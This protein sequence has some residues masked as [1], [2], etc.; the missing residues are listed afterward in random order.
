MINTARITELREREGI[1]QAELA[2]R[3]HVVQNMIAQIERGYKQ[4]SAALLKAIA[5]V[6]GV[7]VD[8]LFK[9]NQHTA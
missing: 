7:T 9:P 1:T 4:P 3:V 2:G 8:S 6:F 5:D